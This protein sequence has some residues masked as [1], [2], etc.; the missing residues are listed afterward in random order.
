MNIQELALAVQNLSFEQ[1]KELINALFAQL[2]K[3]E[4]LADSVVWVGD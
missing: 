3:S 4:S 2:P 1:T